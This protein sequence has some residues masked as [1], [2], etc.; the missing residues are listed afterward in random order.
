LAAT[1]SLPV[2]KIVEA[3]DQPA[4]AAVVKDCF[5]NSTPVYPIGGGTSLE[6]G[7][8]ATQPGIGLSLAKLDR[9]VDYPARDM[10]ITVEAGVTMQTLRETLAKEGQQLPLD[11]PHEDRATLGG[12]VATNFNGPRRYG[13]GSVRDYVIG[14]SAVDGRGM[15]FKGG[16]RVVKNVAGYDFCKLLT[17]SLGTLGVITQLTM[18]LKPVP[19]K[20]MIVACGAADLDEAEKLLAA[21]AE[22]QTTPVAIELLLGPAWRNDPALAVVSATKQC[23]VLLVGLEGTADEVDWMRQR[24]D[25]ELRSRGKITCHTIAGGDAAA[26]WRRLAEFPAG[27]AALTLKINVVPSATTRLI[28]LVQQIDPQ[29]SIQA[30]AGSGVIVAQLSALPKGGLARTLIGQLQPAAA[31]ALGHVT[32]LANP[33]GTEATQQVTWGDTD[34]PYWLMTEVKRKFDPAGILNPKRFVYHGA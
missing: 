27:E 14:V 31:K 23:S 29:C 30:H 16:G 33:T 2:S 9:I 4:V 20:S 8:P 6:F 34:A 15:P 10:T 28:A 17:G 3:A 24:L 19:Q 26:L 7:L 13:Y 32:V 18:K 5:E 22:S 1:Q 11:V 12:V 21:L 25:G